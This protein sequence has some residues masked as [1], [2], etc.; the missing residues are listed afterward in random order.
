M[1]TTKQ[2]LDNYL[3]RITAIQKAIV[4]GSQ[5]S[6]LPLPSGDPPF[7]LNLYLPGRF[8][9]NVDAQ[10]SVLTIICQMQLIRGKSTGTFQEEAETQIIADYADVLWEFT[11]DENYKRLIVGAFTRIQ[12]GFIPGSVKI[13]TMSRTE[14]EQANTGKLLGSFYN[15]EWQHKM[16]RG[17]GE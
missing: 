14:R 16:T 4:T 9:M 7:W 1:A 6:K 3:D 17:L 2:D 12:P 11:T 8:R 13:A 10:S 5:A 15:L